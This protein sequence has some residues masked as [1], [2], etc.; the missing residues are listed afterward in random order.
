YRVAFDF[1]SEGLDSL[2]TFNEQADSLAKLLAAFFRDR[3]AAEYARFFRRQH[4]AH[5]RLVRPRDTLIARSDGWFGRMFDRMKGREFE[6]HIAYDTLRDRTPVYI[7]PR[8]IDYGEWETLR[9]YPLLNW[10]MGVVY[11]LEEYDQRIYPQGELARRTVGL[12][13]DRGNYGIEEAYREELAGVDGQALRQRIAR[14]FSGRVPGPAYQEP[15]D[16]C[17]VV[18]TLEPDLQDVADKALRTQLAAQNAV[19]GT[20]LVME[21]QTGEIV[22]M[23]NLGRNADGSYSERENYA[24]SRSMEPGSTF[25]LATM[26]ALLDDA[27]FSPATTYDTYDGKPVTVG[28]AEN[29]R[30]D[31][32]GDRLIDFRRAVAMSSNVYFAKAVWDC[33]GATGRKQ[34]YSDYLHKVLHLGET[35]GLERLGERPPEITTDWKVPD[36]GV[37]LVK[38]AYGYR[39]RMTPIQLLTFYNAIANDGRMVAPLL[40]RSLQRNGKEQERFEPRVIAPSIC[41]KEA[42]HE[43]RRC[44]QAVCTEGTASAFFS[45]TTRLRVAAKTGTAQITESRYSDHYLGSMV[46]FFPADAPR[47]TV[48][49]AIETQMQPGKTYYGGPLAGPVVSRM[50]EFIH[51]RG[52]IRSLRGKGPL[53]YPQRIKGGDIA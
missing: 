20:T 23:A 37:M 46:A 50:V 21:V 30:D 49:T 34:Q 1:G 35:V 14:R 43:V 25:K 15:V 9:T 22:A 31:H 47:Y 3:S 48:L 41:S 2:D 7:L 27:H 38:M 17:D 40:V 5:Y 16:G 28:H 45:D 39:V 51:N 4:A 11:Q 42:L 6:K 33:Y 26:L 53:Y 10:N 52:Q 32:T 12:T 29:I 24:L 13:G 36:P 19:W 44:L 18:T 8:E